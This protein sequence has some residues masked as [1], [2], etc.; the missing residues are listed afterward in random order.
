[1]INPTTS[2]LYLAVINGYWNVLRFQIYESERSEWQY[3]G[4]P[5][6]IATK[7]DSHPTKWVDLPEITDRWSKDTP[8]DG[9]LCVV[10]LVS[11][12]NEDHGLAV[13][14]YNTNEFVFEFPYDNWS[15]DYEDWQ[16]DGWGLIK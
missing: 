8:L 13:M 15:K 7:Y 11:S 12:K 5:V 14:K 1:M 10:H 16:I 9:Q 3:P 2:G 6:D 4:N